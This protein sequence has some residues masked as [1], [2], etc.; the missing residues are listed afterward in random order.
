MATCTIIN[1]ATLD[2]WSPDA[3]TKMNLDISAQPS[4]H[5][6]ERGAA[7]T[8][9]V[10]QQPFTFTIE[11]VV[12]ESSFYTTN[13]YG[14]ERIT[15]WIDFLKEL[16]LGY[17]CTIETYRHGTLTNMVLTSAPTPIDKYRDTRFTLQFQQI[18][19]VSAQVLYLGPLPSVKVIIGSKAP[20]CVCPSDVGEQPT[21]NVTPATGTSE[22][23]TSGAYALKYWGR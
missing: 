23:W 15:A 2:F 1:D 17:T 20:T 13:S 12:S 4:Q 9:H 14:P 18:K 21:S 16:S 7:I 11:G 19:I 22:D 10:Q 5:P 3:V 6:V 8:D